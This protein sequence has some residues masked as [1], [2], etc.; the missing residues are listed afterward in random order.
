MSSEP[1]IEQLPLIDLPKD[2]PMIE[3]IQHCAHWGPFSALVEN[4]RVVGAEPWAGD[5]AP[6][7]MLAAIPDL[8]DPKVRIDRPYVREGY[9]ASGPSSSRRGRGNERFVPVDWE[10]ALDL[11]SRE[12]RRVIDTHGNDSIFAGS[13]GWTSAG[14][15]HHAQSQVKRFFNCLGGYTGHVDTYS[16]GAG[17]VIARHILGNDGYGEPN[18]I[19]MIAEH[20]DLLV[21]CG[22]LSPRT[23]QVEGGGAGRRMLGEHLKRM[24]ARGVRIVLV[25]PR[26]DDIPDWVDAEWWPIVPNTDTALLIGM[27]GEI[28]ASGRADHD[29]LDRCCSGADKYL[30]YLKG[31]NDETPKT[32]EWAA[33]ITGLDAA[34]IRALAR[35]MTAKRTF[36]SISWALQRAVHGEQPWWAGTSLAAIAGQMGHAGGGVAYGLG[37]VTNANAHF[38][39]APISGLSH[40]KKPNTSFIPVARIA[41]ML[42]NPGAPFTY[43]GKSHNFPDI[44][45]VYW[46]GGNPYHHHQD[47]GRL[48]EAWEQPET[49][50]VQE[51][52]WTAT[53]K[54]ADIVFPATTTLERNDVSGGR[55][56]DMLFA[57]KKCVAPYADAR[58][59]FEI[60]RGLSQRLGIEAAFTE[61]LGE[62]AWVR[63]LY[64]DT[65]N[66]IMKSGGSMPAFDEF[67]E[68]GLAEIPEVPLEPGLSRLRADPDANPLKTESG[69]LV[70]YSKTLEA[71]AYPDCPPH[72]TWM[73]PPEWLGS[74]KRASYPFHLLSA[75]SNGRL[76]SQL[77]WGRVSQGEKQSGREAILVNPDDARRLGL[78]DGATALV[79]NGRGRCLAGVRVSADIRPGVV[80][81]PTGAWWQPVETAEGSLCIA[82]NANVLTLDVP[83]SAFSGGCAAHTCL[84]AVEPYVGNAP[85][86]TFGEPEIA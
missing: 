67:W 50:I 45:L 40:G 4:G 22:A 84:V 12:I 34:K 47:L 83:A 35:E 13:Y 82:G 62:M 86:P 32:A 15:F 76:H 48:T 14:R 64:E 16:V 71:C 8:M 3:R 72:A 53:A 5:P 70:L 85:L 29:F 24:K 61:G 19:K 59:D 63:R 10:A 38:P 1:V 21:V 54:R 46:A 26:R 44:R 78:T 11:A 41:D 42:L 79:R 73:E 6:S 27:A 20:T 39:L 33:A 36:I 43:E 56:A 30:A 25:S 7:H 17:A 49:V 80:V 75:Q 60:M 52:A 37:S 28:V 9:L 23:S 57:M 69:K 77:D 66:G 18:S 58:S 2:R 31:E 68:I 65:R 55:R 51:I 74:A 81:L